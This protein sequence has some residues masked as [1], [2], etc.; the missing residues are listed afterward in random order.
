MSAS[1]LDNKDLQDSILT[2]FV[3]GVD[4]ARGLL[5]VPCGSY[6]DPAHAAHHE[7]R[8]PRAHRI[9]AK[10][11]LSI[12]IYTRAK[13]PAL[14]PTGGVAVS[15]NS[16]NSSSSDRAAE[17]SMTVACAKKLLEPGTDS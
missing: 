6:S 5:S 1:V 10:R 16:A 4:Q 9:F 13:R 17:N 2:S 8:K 12:S 14:V 7:A 3:V 15:G 11:R